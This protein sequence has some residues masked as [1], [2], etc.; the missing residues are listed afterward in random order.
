MILPKVRFL[1]HSSRIKKEEMI[2]R[3]FPLFE[4][5]SLVRKGGCKPKVRKKLVVKTVNP[6]IVYSFEKGNNSQRLCPKT[7]YLTP[8]GRDLQPCTNAIFF[9]SF[10][11]AE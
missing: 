9:T 10:F 11:L 2:T 5:F 3:S 4:D 6:E 7:V 1:V 8:L